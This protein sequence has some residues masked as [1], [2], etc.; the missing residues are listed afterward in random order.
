M[1]AYEPKSYHPDG[2]YIVLGA[3]IASINEWANALDVGAKCIALRRNPAPDEQDLN[4]PRCLFESLGIDAFA[5]LPFE[6]R[7]QFLG[8]VLKG[9]T[10]APAQLAR[11]DREGPPRGALR[12]AARARSTSSSAGPPGCACTSPA[13]TARTRAGSTSPAWS[14]APASTSRSLTLPLLRRLIEHYDLPVA[15]GPPQAAHQLRRARASTARTRA[16]A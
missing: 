12:G 3:G 1:Q 9:T 15:G 16:C 10:P 7:V 13:A 2:R 8:N 14:P 4:V 5:G 6:A 11:A